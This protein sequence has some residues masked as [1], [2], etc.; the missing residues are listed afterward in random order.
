M[1][2]IE[3]QPVSGVKSRSTTLSVE[4]V[5][6]TVGNSL[7]RFLT[8]SVVVVLLEASGGGSWPGSAV[9]NVASPDTRFRVHTTLKTKMSDMGCNRYIRYTHKHRSD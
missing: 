5:V 9:E 3:L 6:M 7:Q 1:E 8:V 2:E 4:G